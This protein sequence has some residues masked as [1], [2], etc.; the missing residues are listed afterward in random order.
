MFSYKRESL[1][2]FSTISYIDQIKESELLNYYDC[3]KELYFTQEEL[4]KN[5]LGESKKMYENGYEEIAKNI[6][7]L[8]RR[9]SKDKII[10]PNRKLSKNI[11]NQIIE[12]NNKKDKILQIKNKFNKKLVDYR[13]DF[14]LKNK[15]FQK[16]IT[17]THP[18]AAEYILN[19]EFFFK[20]SYK[21]SRYSYI[22]RNI[23]KTNTISYSGIVS[24]NH[25]LNIG[26]IVNKKS[27]PYFISLFLFLLTRLDNIRNNIQ[28][29]DPVKITRERRMALVTSDYFLLYNI[30]GFFIKEDLLF[31]NDI[32]KKLFAL[33]LNKKNIDK[34]F[35]EKELELLINNNIIIP[36]FSLY[37]SNEENLKKLC[38]Y[39]SLKS[40][41]NKEN[42][43]QEMYGE[44]LSKI[45]NKDE[46]W[47]VRMLI[48]EISKTNK[49]TSFVYKNSND[50]NEFI[51]EINFNNEQITHFKDIVYF[52]LEFHKILSII[53]TELDYKLKPLLDILFDLE[54]IL[55][56]KK[57]FWKE[58]YSDIHSYNYN[59]KRSFMIMYNQLDDGRSIINNIFPG[60]GFLIGRELPKMEK[61]IE[62]NVY[63]QI[64]SNISNDYEMYELVLDNFGSSLN[65][66]GNSS[67]PKLYWPKDFK[68]IKIDF[69]NNTMIFKLKE[70]PINICY[71]GSIPPQQYYGAK[72]ILLQ[73]ISPWKMKTNNGLLNNIIN[74][75]KTYSINYDDLEDIVDWSNLVKTMLDL[76]RYF[77]NKGLPNKFFLYGKSKKISK[78]KPIYI[79][80]LNIEGI[81][82]FY[83]L[84]KENKSVFIMEM[85]PNTKLYKERKLEEHIIIVNEEEL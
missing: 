50:K 65:N 74:K 34:I 56:F 71:L 1:F 42:L 37:Y 55:L 11:N 70:K 33:S 3:E 20:E 26:T 39:E 83:D 29:S 32:I 76:N 40:L 30:S 36:D 78:R 81:K 68:N 79:T 45:Q 80:L 35:S 67:L 7:S 16:Y 4:L 54:N 52:D 84:L 21:K 8:K 14:F 57:Q 47:F 22:Q 85:V 62:E 46:E 24:F 31:R 18:E 48:E 82:I 60:N 10:N 12:Y 69:I 66:T 63:E 17:E 58:K 72:K 25:N 23:L 53:E 44:I 28:Y 41:Y 19:E 2:D 27:N 38:K 6:S 43:N 51:T 15:N 73:I 9:V 64:K 75:R 61:T 13:Y 49:N 59:E 5:L 77:F